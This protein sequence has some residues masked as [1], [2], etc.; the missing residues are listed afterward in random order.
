MI[1]TF[2]S[3]KGG[4]GRSMALANVAEWLYLQGLRVVIIDWDLEAPGLESFFYRSTD[5]LELVRSQLGLI[6]M[7]MAYKRTFPR[8]SFNNEKAGQQK[9]G[10]QGLSIETVIAELREKLP[11]VADSLYPIHAPASTNGHHAPALWLLPAG[12]RAGDRFP[13]YAQAVQSFDWADFYAS[14]HGEAYFEWLRTQLVDEDLAD[15]VLIDSRTGVTEMGGVCTR[16]M[17]DVVVS[18]CV[19]NV[20]NLSGV[21][22]MVR[23]FTRAEIVRKR[24]RELSVVVVPTRIDV[25]ELDARNHFEKEF[26]HRLD[27]FTPP[28]FQTVRSTFWDLTIQYI[29][30]YAYTEKLAINAPD[31]ARELEDAYKKLAAHLVLLAHGPSGSRVRK[32]YVPELRRVFGT[33]LPNVLVAYTGTHNERVADELRTHLID[34]GLTLS[35]DPLAFDGGRDEWRQYQMMID[36]TKLLLIVLSSA[37]PFPDTVHQAWRYARQQGIG[38]YF[39]S[40]EAN[41][42]TRSMSVLPQWLRKER[43]YD[44]AT[45]RDA[46][47]RQL[48]SPI[49]PLRVPFM[50]PAVPDGYIERPEVFQQCKA[51]VLETKRVGLWGPP[52][53]GKKALAIMLCHDEDLL[54]HFTDGILWVTLGLNPNIVGELTSL[55]AVLTGERPSFGDEAEATARLAEKLNGDHSLLVIDDVWDASHVQSFLRAA[56]RCTLILITRDVN[57]AVAI[58]AKIITVGEVTADEAERI[59]TAH[60]SPSPAEWPLCRTLLHSVGRWPL[61][62]KLANAELRKRLDQGA[63][64]S[65]ALTS[66][67][68]A[69]EQHGV[70]ALDQPNALDRDQAIGRTL[71]LSLDQLRTEERNRY[72]QLTFFPPEKDI[73]LHEVSER[74]A[75]NEIE[76]EKRLQRFADLA[77]LTYDLS[78]KTVRLH[79]LLHSYSF[80]QSPN[81]IATLDTRFARFSP[82]EQAEVRRAFTRLVR[83]ASP[84]EGTADTLVNA[85]LSEFTGPTQDCLRALAKDRFVA[86]DPSPTGDG[87]IVRIAQDDIRRDWS[88][89]HEW[90]KQDHEFLLWR[91]QLRANMADWEK[92]VRDP[93]AL[94]IGA[95]LTVALHWQETR[96][97]DLHDSE[98]AYIATSLRSERQKKR[99]IALVMLLVVTSFGA[100]LYVFWQRQYSYEAGISELPSRERS[101]PSRTPPPTNVGTE[102][103]I[104][105]AAT[106]VLEANRHAQRGATEL[107]FLSYNNALDLNPDSVEAY[108][109]RGNLY[110]Q[111]EDF[112][113]AI[114]DYGKAIALKANAADAYLNRGL[115]WLHKGNTHEAIADFDHALARDPQNP[116]TYFNRGVARENSSLTALAIADYSK[117][118]DFKKDYVEAYFNRGLA[119]QGTGEKEQASA[120]FTQVLNLS[121]DVQTVQAARA[122]LQ[123]L[124]ALPEPPSQVSQTRVY[125]H[126]ADQADKSTLAVVTTTLVNKGYHVPESEFVAKRT[127]GDVRYFY[128]EDAQQATEI[129]RLVESSLAEQGVK[130]DLALVALKAA[131]FPDAQQGSIEVW[132]PSLSRRTPTRAYK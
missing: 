109:G 103:R 76:A 39:V 2:Y 125:L 59:L 96:A 98:R 19:P 78:T 35:A 102:T 28:V 51:A 63:T 87:E 24:N 42:L 6:D 33:L 16:Q 56:Q 128:K 12:W 1:Y 21:E 112:D 114:A 85:K 122:R 20:Q 48:Q 111:Q 126:Y 7:L 18:F 106:F 93:G 9:E 29:P 13:V 54:S 113:R 90:L 60:L 68:Q 91:Q 52:G 89:L 107:A 118:I 120:D 75:V 49:P 101:V 72:L 121:T 80:H 57:I 82:E 8:L 62:L 22:T 88:R 3:Y 131:K 10:A 31:S 70:I 15:V 64:L 73:A 47:A 117:A 130:L 100:V 26:R 32:P 92:T 4:V 81:Y 115:S 123:Q 25:S 27:S 67:Q 55:Y 53:S 97:S 77:L 83:V 99:L 43:I 5:D 124:G 44:L 110:D 116:I 38:V 61:M 36:Q 84:T 71:A 37:S 14:Y 119:Y 58:G 74:W 45:D 79:S 105:Q 65:E 94:L 129:K 17:A 46:L 66:L 23:S 127:D 95:P 34:Q 69:I 50:V 40:A 11:S 132:I 30:K 104:A 108:L 41:G 86:I